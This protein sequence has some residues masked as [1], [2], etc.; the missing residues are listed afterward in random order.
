[1][2][3]TIQ[4]PSLPQPCPKVPP[5]DRST[6]PFEAMLPEI[7]LYA[8]VSFRQ[9]DRE[10][11]EEAVEEA[12]AHALVTYRRLVERGKAGYRLPGRAG[13]LRRAARQGRP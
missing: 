6:D 4:R 1:M 5:S 11:R 13:P 3:A 8:W 10:A 7:R 2:I 9:L 12:I